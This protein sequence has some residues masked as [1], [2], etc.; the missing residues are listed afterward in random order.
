MLPPCLLWGDSIAVGAASR[1]PACAVVA[2]VGA[3][4]SRIARW[5]LP[6]F[7]GPVVVSAGSNDP[8]SPT[9][10]RDVAA[11]RARI[12]GPIIWIVPMDR[13]AA[14]ATLSACLPGDRAAWL[15][16]IPTRDGVH[17]RSYDDL[18][19]EIDRSGPCR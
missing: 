2:R 10:R 8:A 4:A 17:P 7:Q 1:Y 13:R 12:V 16:R 11:I 18:K 3:P 15:A 6:A 19:V 14:S 9:L 5:S